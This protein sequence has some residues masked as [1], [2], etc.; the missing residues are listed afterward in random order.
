MRRAALGS[1]VEEEEDEEEE[2]ESYSYATLY[3]LRLD[4]PFICLYAESKIKIIIIKKKKEEEESGW[5]GFIY[6]R[7]NEQVLVFFGGGLGFD[8]N[9][10]L[11][12]TLFRE[13]RV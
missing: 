11:R 8:A 6:Y 3:P 12:Q 9:Q 5:K 13:S 2:K 7:M 10:L 4:A 1:L